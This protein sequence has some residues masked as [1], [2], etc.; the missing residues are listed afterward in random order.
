MP[1]MMLVPKRS[2]N[3]PVASP[4]SMEGGN[5]DSPVASPLSIPRAEDTE[6][7]FKKYHRHGEKGKEAFE[8]LFDFYGGQGESDKGVSNL[9][10]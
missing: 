5:V 1:L 9:Q 2:P 10:L 4:S 6:K 8:K 3:S 7:L